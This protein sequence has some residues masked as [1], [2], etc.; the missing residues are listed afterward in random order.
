VGKEE[1]KWQIVRQSKVGELHNVATRYPKLRQT[2]HGKGKRTR[3]YTHG[4]GKTE[5]TNATKKPQEL[6]WLH[7]K[8]RST[9]YQ[10]MHA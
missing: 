7:L 10:C 5:T 9:H 6:A 1:R 3:R 2:T 8:K 4:G